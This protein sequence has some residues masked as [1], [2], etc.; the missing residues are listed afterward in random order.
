MH[1][2]FFLFVFVFYSKV[3]HNAKQQ[4]NVAVDSV[5]LVALEKFEYQATNRLLLAALEKYEDSVTT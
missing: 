3:C 4:D 2:F 5:L 1:C